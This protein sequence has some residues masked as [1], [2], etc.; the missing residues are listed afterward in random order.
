MFAVCEPQS[1]W[2]HPLCRI[3]ASFCDLPSAGTPGSRGLRARL[4]PAEPAE[5]AS[6]TEFDRLLPGRCRA[7]WLGI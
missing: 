6:L 4:L 1:K 3:L 2:L 5:Q 7:C